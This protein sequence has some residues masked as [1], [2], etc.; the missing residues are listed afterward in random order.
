MP[1]DTPADLLPFRAPPPLPTVILRHTLPNGDMHYDWLLARDPAGVQPLIAFRAS[2]RPDEVPVD[3]AIALERIADHRPRYLTY[4]G[5]ISDDRGHVMQVAR[6]VIDAAE[7]TN[8]GWVLDLNW[9]RP[10]RIGFR[11]VR[12]E[13]PNERDSQMFSLPLSRFIGNNDDV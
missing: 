11:R 12:I 9:L 8:P 2:V 6:G 4:E 3:S 10:A 13:R 5:P 1:A 7:R